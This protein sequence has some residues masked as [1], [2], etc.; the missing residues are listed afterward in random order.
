MAS[1][2]LAYKRTVID[3]FLE[4]APL[5]GDGPPEPPSDGIITELA[6]QLES[7]REHLPQILRWDE[8]SDANINIETMFDGKWRY[9]AMLDPDLSRLPDMKMILTA[10]LH[11][12]YK[13]AKYIIWRPHLYRLL[14]S[15]SNLTEDEISCC[16]EAFEVC[17][18]YEDFR[19]S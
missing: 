7:W 6:R 4:R 13:Y 11:T 19:P 10:C 12:R 18:K 2:P 5:D 17:L 16:Q 9:V 15:P 1:V 14:H 8:A 3:G